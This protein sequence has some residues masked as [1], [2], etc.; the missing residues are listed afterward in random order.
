MAG[1]NQSIFRRAY[2]KFFLN[3]V[4]GILKR[5]PAAMFYMLSFGIKKN[6]ADFYTDFFIRQYRHIE[7]AVALARKMHLNESSTDIILDIGGGNGDTAA[8]FAKHFPKTKIVVME[9][10]K[11]NLANMAAVLSANSNLVLIPKAAGSK[12]A[13]EKI[14]IGRNQNASSF[15]EM[16]ADDKSKLFSGDI[17]VAD[18]ESV[19]VV[20]I[21]DIVLASEKVSILK[22]DIQGAELDAL[23]GASETLK[24]TS[25]VVLEVNNHDHYKGAP[26]YNEIDAY[27]CEQDFELFD[28]HPS[29]YD[30]G[31][32]KE[33]DVIYRK[34]KTG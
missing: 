23:K 7:S 9:P 24:R 4:A 2:E 32:L 27:L 22:M 31:K 30:D 12:T 29:T 3:T 11:K 16:K 25:I 1:N 10:V 28:I 13:T 18:V 5:D 19:E 34:G 21:D 33:W 20:R 17:E 8:I 6:V 15:F 26:R 14:F